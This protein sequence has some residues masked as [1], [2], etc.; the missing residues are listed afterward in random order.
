MTVNLGLTLAEFLE[1]LPDPM[2]EARFAL[3]RAVMTGD[4]EARLI[5]Y[6]RLRSAKINECKFCQ[7]IGFPEEQKIAQIRDPEE[8]E[9]LTERERLALILCDRLNLD[10]ESIDQPFFER[11]RQEFSVPE[12]LELAYAIKWLGMLQSLNDLFE[13]QAD[14]AVADAVHQM[15]YG[16]ASVDRSHP[17]FE[18][19][20]GMR[21]S[22]DRVLESES[23]RRE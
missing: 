2:R 9:G 10:P 23:G 22:R 11:L 1:E 14:A 13:V 15:V 6:V 16:E 5:E 3:T 8:A 20:D 18:R 7:A 4:L 19:K 12:I 21:Q 17:Y